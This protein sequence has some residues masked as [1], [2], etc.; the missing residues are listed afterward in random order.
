MTAVLL[1]AFAI[2]FFFYYSLDTINDPVFGI[3]FIPYH[4]AGASF[5]GGNKIQ[6]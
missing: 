2:A 3:D 4:V 6:S 5:S 1:I